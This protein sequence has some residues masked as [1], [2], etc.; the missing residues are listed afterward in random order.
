VVWFG[1][2]RSG[3]LAVLSPP[4]LRA[5]RGK[6]SNIRKERPIHAAERSTSERRLP[7]CKPSLL[8]TRELNA[9]ES[10]GLFRAIS[11]VSSSASDR[12]TRGSSLAAA[13]AVVVAAAAF[14]GLFA[15]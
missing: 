1:S 3:L 11:S 13:S 4:S 14:A 12:L 8:G 5:K 6:P 9:R 7:G 2:T 10:A 15:K